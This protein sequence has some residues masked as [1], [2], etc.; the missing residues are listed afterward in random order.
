MTSCPASA[1]NGRVNAGTDITTPRVAGM[2]I[3]GLF[4]LYALAAGA[5]TPVP[6]GVSVAR[7]GEIR[8]ELALNGSLIPRRT[9]RL[10]AEIDGQVA[11]ILVDDG[12][13]V[14]ANAV[15]LRLDSRLARIDIEAARAR[16]DEARA[17][18]AESERRHRELLE[19][20]K[21][22]HVAATNVAA[23]R[24]QI[25]IDAAAVRQAEAALARSSELLE[26]HTVYAP[27]NAVVRH[28]LVEKGEWVE[29]ST[30]VAELVDVEVL[31]LEVAV[32][33]FYYASVG[34]GTPVVIRL[35]A[36]PERSFEARVTRKIPVGEAAS[37]TFRVRIDI[38]N[39]DGRLAPGMSA[40]AG[41][42]VAPGDTAP[43]LLLPRDAV[44]RKPDGSANVWVIVVEDG[45]TKAV[46]RLIETGRAWRDLIEI[47]QGDV[48]PGEQVVVRGN[49]ILT[50]GQSVLV[51]DESGQDI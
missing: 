38:P 12:D 15:V 21:N 17:R 11:E 27:F 24:A 32:P 39:D 4:V 49:E 8:D 14:N 44:V 28:K 19:L 26:R 51:A 13:R 37:R 47:V 23:A 36:M 1:D 40:R 2:F 7:S 31:R 41:L 46:P 20:K 30:A 9:S 34:V 45:V 6:V 29:T 10:S 43:A 48:T 5:E 35:D 42:R 16:L 50:P 22:Q 18:H 3:A 33:Q 25:D